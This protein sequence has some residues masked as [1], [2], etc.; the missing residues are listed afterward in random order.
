[1]IS[2]IDLN[3]SGMFKF[4]SVLIA[5]LLFINGAGVCSQTTSDSQLWMD[6]EL[7]YTY[8]QRF[9][10]QDELSYQTLVSGGSYWYSLNSTPAFEF[11]LNPHIDLIT[12]VPL[13]YTLQGRKM[14]T[15]E[16]RAMVGS[17][18]YLTPALRPQVRFLV[19]LEERWAYDRAIDNWDIGNR[20]RLRAEVIY[21]VN[22]KSYF[23]DKMWYFIGDT[24]LF[25][26]TTQDINE[27]F[28]N[29]TRFRMGVGYRLNY[30]MR[31]EG[32]YTLQFSRNTIDD[33]FN[34]VD[35]IIR[36]RFKYYLK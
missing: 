36:L 20:I 8:K 34:S 15:F 21:P 4:K 35:N 28:A 30:K 14:S 6:A 29:R 32:I 27:R 33:D 25:L 26:S 22:K 16:V 17:R 7:N 18:I 1:M 11:N 3:W 10:F 13:S 5:A 12:S 24:E 2:R 23:E 31:F 9:L 19:R